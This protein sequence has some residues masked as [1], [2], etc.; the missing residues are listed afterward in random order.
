MEGFDR[1]RNPLFLHLFAKLS[2]LPHK[3]PFFKCIEESNQPSPIPIHENSYRYK[4]SNGPNPPSN[5]YDHYSNSSVRRYGKEVG[6][7]FRPLHKYLFQTINELNVFK[8]LPPNLLRN[9][10][11]LPGT[12]IS[13][14]VLKITSFHP[15]TCIHPLALTQ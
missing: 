4:Y 3:Q 5:S 10:P 2:L 1:E 6:K 12:P 13:I 9:L 14:H 11:H 7:Q 15:L 8:W